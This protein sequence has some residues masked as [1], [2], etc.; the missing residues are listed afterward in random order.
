MQI[1][2]DRASGVSLTDQ[3]YGAIRG[4][5]TSGTLSPNT[6]VP[7]WQDL[8]AQ[9]GVSRGTVKRAYDRLKDDQLIDTKGAGGTWVL[10]VVRTEMHVEESRGPGLSGM[11]YDFGAGALPFQM[12][13]PS[14]DGFPMKP[15]AA[16]WRNA[17]LQDVAAPLVYPDPRG[18]IGLRKEV[19][20]YLAISRGLRCSVDRIFIT[21]GFAGALGIVINV[22]GLRGKRVAIEEPGYPRTTRALQQCLVGTLPVPVDAG[23]VDTEILMQSD[24]HLDAVFVTPGQQAPLGMTMSA[25]RR[26]ALLDWANA[27]GAWVI[28]DDYA[29]ELQLSGRAAP[30]LASLDATGRVIHIGSFSKTLSPKLRL[31]FLVVPENVAPMF[32]EFMAHLA[33]AGGAVSQR[34]LQTFMA[35]GHF[36]RHLRRMKELY[37]HRKNHVAET[38]TA[39]MGPDFEL[40]VEGALSVRLFLSEAC[41]DVNVAAKA[42]RAGLAPVP[43][44]MWYLTPRRRK[45]LLLG[46]THINEKNLARDIS[47]LRSAIG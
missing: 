42:F 25:A 7:S 13:I 10:E 22:L 34:A 45:G 16:A 15:W 27:T 29:G 24:E 41:D 32:G 30:A 12:G 38:L 39:G 5:I 46:I 28:E 20:A 19:A 17:M 21:T 40:G 8:A 33:P 18:E 1:S 11:F 44:S 35:Q 6:R 14:Q 26:A 43:L 9:L 3:I 31:G 36:M 37:K 2:I 4:G 23:G 47:T